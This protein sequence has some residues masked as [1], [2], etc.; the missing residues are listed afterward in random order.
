[1]ERVKA[2]IAR[3]DSIDF[4]RGIILVSIFINHIPGNVFE[5][6][7]HK[8]I[9]YSDATEAFVFLSGLSVALAY[10][11]RFISGEITLPFQAIRRRILTIYSVQFFLSLAAIALFLAAA[12][13]FDDDGLFAEHGRDI[14]LD[15]PIKALLAIAGLSHQIGYFNIL[16]LYIVLLVATPAMLA[17]ARQNMSLMLGVSFA[18]YILARLFDIN[19]PTW[20]VE[21]QWFFNPFTWQLLYCLGLYIGLQMHRINDFRNSSFFIVAL[22]TMVL[23]FIL[24]TGVFSTAPELKI[25]SEGLLDLSKTNLGLARF[26]HFMALTYVIFYLS[27]HKFLKVQPIYD[28]L[29]LIGRHSLPVFAAGSLLSSVGQ[30][31]MQ[32]AS[33]HLALWDEFILVGAGIAILYLVARTSAFRRQQSR[34]T[35]KTA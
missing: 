34:M 6:Y 24:V 26:I 23:S 13:L 5:S 19:L 8:N 12:F 15:K 14:I 16:P 30:I 22:V 28:A 1:M 17:L 18:I 32:T 7:T 21:G 2:K 31:M 25:A 11:R 20:P 3:V 4:W 29:C 9:G 35:Q 33:I 10:G 27:L